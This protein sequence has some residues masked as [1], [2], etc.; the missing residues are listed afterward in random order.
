M[1]ES[2]AAFERIREG[3]ARLYEAQGAATNGGGGL[4]SE[5]ATD[6]RETIERLEGAFFNAMDHDFN[7]AAALGKVFEMVRHSNRFLDTPLRPGDSVVLRD[8]FGRLEALLQ[9][10]GFYPNG[11][12]AAAVAE[13]R[14]GAPAE[15]EALAQK[16]L[17]ARA[18]RD[19]EAADSLRQ[20]I[21]A[22]GWVV[23][24][25]PDGYRVK[26]QT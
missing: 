2:R 20:E 1:T 21:A 17:E 7:T 3:I 18:A 4:I 16:R 9:L 13:R 11:L 25:R 6:L 12:S 19:F 24:D 26:K 23:E 10:L 8:V 5:A 15:V 22:L 14:A